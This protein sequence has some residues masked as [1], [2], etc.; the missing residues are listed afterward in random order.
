[1]FRVGQPQPLP[2]PHCVLGNAHAERPKPAYWIGRKAQGRLDLRHVGEAG[3]IGH[4]AEH[5][6]QQPGLR[7][8]AH[9]RNGMPHDHKL[10][11]LHAD[12]LARQVIETG[13]AGD[14]GSKTFRVRR[15]LP[16]CRVKAEE[17][18]D[19]QIVLRDTPSGIADEADAAL[20]QIASSRSPT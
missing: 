18:Q 2:Q 3:E 11:Q 4:P 16:V 8:D 5:G 1:M 17:A 12:A 20:M 19:A 9:C 13:A 14:A 15:A 6:D 10:H 7:H